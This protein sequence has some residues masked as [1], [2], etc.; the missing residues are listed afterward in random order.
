KVTIVP[1]GRAGGYAMMIPKEGE[2]RLL[3]TKSELLDR[4]TGLLGGRVSEELFIGEIGTGAYDDF[5]TATSIAR[6]M[7]TEFGMRDPIGPMY[8]GQSHGPVF[9][10]RVLAHEQY[11]SDAI[12][13]ETEQVMQSIIRSCYERAKEIMQKHEDTAHL[14]ANQ[15]L[16]LEALEKDQSTQLI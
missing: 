10:G 12:A 13:Y 3:Q 5:K 15:L 1:R 8:F 6:A 16:E 9:I 11:F 14:L 7:V 2:D 4:I